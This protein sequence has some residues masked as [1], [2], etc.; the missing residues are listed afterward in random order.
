M[1]NFLIFLLTIVMVSVSCNSKRLNSN[2][3]KTI[4]VFYKGCSDESEII[5]DLDQSIEPNKALLKENNIQLKIDTIDNK[6]GYFLSW[7]GKKKEISSVMT[8]IDFQTSVKDF[9]AIK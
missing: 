1:K 2:N 7:N 6:C 3:D 9:F 5:S 8:D 4:T